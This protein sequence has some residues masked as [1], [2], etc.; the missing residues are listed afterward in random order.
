[1]PPALTFRNSVFCSHCACVLF[2]DLRTNSDFYLHSINWLVFI[3]EAESVYC[4]VRTGS[5]DQTDT[6]LSLG[7]DMGLGY[8]E[9]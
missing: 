1:V 2:T 4:A 8:T 9:E 6:V 3:T 5:S 7:G